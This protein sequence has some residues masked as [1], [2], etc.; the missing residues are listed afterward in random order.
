M[1]LRLPRNRRIFIKCSQL[2]DVD[3]DGSGRMYLAAWEGAGYKGNP[4][5]GYVERRSA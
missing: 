3:V 5:K 2:T 4:G 1:E